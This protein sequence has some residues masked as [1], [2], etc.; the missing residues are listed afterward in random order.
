MESKGDWGPSTEAAHHWEG[1]D[2]GEGKGDGSSEACNVV[3]QEVKVVR[4]R[5]AYDVHE[6][7]H[8]AVA[9]GA[10]KSGGPLR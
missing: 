6:G 4:E 2:G 3:V 7:V 10:S 9:P 1:D 5:P 8:D